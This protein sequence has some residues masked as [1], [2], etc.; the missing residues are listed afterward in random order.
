[1][2]NIINILLFALTALS[3]SGKAYKA[4]ILPG[5]DIDMGDGVTWNS[6]TQVGTQV[7]YVYTLRLLDAD[8]LPNTK[9]DMKAIVSGMIL[10]QLQV[11]YDAE[12]GDPAQTVK[13]LFQEGLTFHY[14]YLDKNGKHLFVIE[15]GLKDMEK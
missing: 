4:D 13:R 11:D 12:R 2:K 14:T 6:M 7:K 15:A 3:L 9:E 10:G 5:K 8:N 1:M